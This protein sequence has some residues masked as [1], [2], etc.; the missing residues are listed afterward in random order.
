M[1][2]VDKN[3]MIAYEPSLE[4][5]AWL[6]GQRKIDIPL[7]DVV[8]NI[9]RGLPTMH[10]VRFLLDRGALTTEQMKGFAVAVEGHL[11]GL[12][13]YETMTSILSQSGQVSAEEML[14]QFDSARKILRD[15]RPHTSEKTIHMYL[16][17]FVL[18]GAIASA[19]TGLEEGGEK[20][21]NMA[22]LAG[23]TLREGATSCLIMAFYH[24]S[25]YATQE[26]VASLIQTLA[27]IIKKFPPEE[28]DD[29]EL[30]NVSPIVV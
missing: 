25:R 23:R 27:Q 5:N 28:S 10:C 22:R 29:Y 8:E 4:H 13:D 21:E 7:L 16:L 15:A 11:P 2:T 26:E 1:Q 20:Q 14:L 6:E 19:F 24:F 17:G 3:E 18:H 9:G 30:T 12:G